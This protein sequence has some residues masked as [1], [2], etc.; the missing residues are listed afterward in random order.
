MPPTIGAR[1]QYAAESSGTDLQ[2]DSASGRWWAA[3]AFA[4]L[5]AGGHAFLLGGEYQGNYRQDQSAGFVGAAGPDLDIRQRSQRIGLYTQDDLRVTKTLHLSL[6]L[7]F[8][9]LAANA[10]LSPRLA[11]I[12]APDSATTVKIAYGRAF[13]AP[14]EYDSITR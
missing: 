10:E 7:R 11:L 12:V 14:N 8:D 4:T 6:G 1:T 13:R 2:T 5:R 3:E 9:H